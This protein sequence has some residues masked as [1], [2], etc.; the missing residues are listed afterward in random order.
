LPRKPRQAWH[1]GNIHEDRALP[2]MRDSTR[3]DIDK[4]LAPMIAEPLATAKWPDEDWK[5]V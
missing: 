4:T 3:H 5:R 1:I 2:P